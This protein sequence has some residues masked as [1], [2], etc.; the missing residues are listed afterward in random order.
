MRYSCRHHPMSPS[1]EHSGRNADL[2][3][4]S[5]SRVCR[6]YDETWRGNCHRSVQ[7]QPGVWPHR[8]VRADYLIRELY[9]RCS[10]TPCFPALQYLP[11]SSADHHP[12]VWQPQLPQ[13]PRRQSDPRPARHC[14]RPSLFPRPGLIRHRSRPHSRN[15]RWRG[16]PPRRYLQY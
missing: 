11:R 2:C 12:V 13:T 1:V 3:R 9:R 10:P 5:R 6:W 8:I 15:R 14:H 16:N 7:D 4:L